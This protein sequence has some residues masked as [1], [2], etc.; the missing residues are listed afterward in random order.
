MVANANPAE[1]LLEDELDALGERLKLHLIRVVDAPERACRYPCGT[2]GR[3]DLEECLPA[4]GRDRWRTLI[5]APPGM[6][7]A[8]E[9]ML[10]RLGLPQSRI[11]AE[12]FRYHYGLASASGRRSLRVQA[13]MLVA[14]AVAVVAFALHAH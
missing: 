8:V 1:I 9:T 13:A 6:I 3:A 4:A 11:H 10:S 12:R 14:V 5:C 7:D 2:G